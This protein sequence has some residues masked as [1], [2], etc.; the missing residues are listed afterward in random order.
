MGDEIMMNKKGSMA[1]R[2][3]MFCIVI[4]A[5]ILSIASLIVF[6][7]ADEYENTG[8]RSNY[9][10][11]GI[12]NLGSSVLGEANS[13]V[14]T[15]SDSID[16]SAGSFGV[17]TGVILGVPAILKT[18]ILSPVYVGTAVSTMMISLNIPSEISI[19]VKTGIILS[20]YIVIIFVI[21]SALSRGGTKL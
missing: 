20:L 14:A 10:A 5:V 18:V 7:I 21:I 2:D 1:L 15:M 11:N 8:M 3:I 9:S 6:D 13:S 12:G 4:F 19:I 17:L 16:E